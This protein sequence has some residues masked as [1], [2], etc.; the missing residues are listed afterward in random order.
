MSLPKKCFISHSYRDSDERD[1]LLSL[2]PKGVKA[3]IFPPIT[4]APEQ[5]VS[6][7]LIDAILACDGLIYLN[8]DFSSQSFWVAFERDYALRAGKRVYSFAKGQ[9]VLTSDTSSPMELR[10]FPIWA[11]EDTSRVLSIVETMREDRFLLRL[12][13]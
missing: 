12:I 8:G 2:L 10:L 4:V 9:V 5:M 1:R 3:F 6:S 7:H 13:S 11:A